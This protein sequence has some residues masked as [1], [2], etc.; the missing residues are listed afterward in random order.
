MRRLVALFY[1]I[2]A[3]ATAFSQCDGENLIQALPPAQQELLQAQADAA[4]YPEGLL[5]RATRGDTSI[6]W[7]GTYHFRH[8]MTDTHLEMIKPLIETA[9]RVYLEVSRD[10]TAQ[11]EREI[12]ADPSIMFL[13][14]GPT[15]PELLGEA[16]WATYKA[17][18]NERAIPG[19]MAAKF[20]PI[21]A[22]MM[23]GI[24]P[25]E[26]RA[27]V[28]NDSGIDELVGDYAAEIGN[29]SQSLEDFRTLLTML[30]SF[31]QDEQ[32]DMIRLF[33]A[34]ADQADD[35]AYTLRETYLAQ[36]VALI[37][38]YSKMMSL[39]LGGPDAADDFAQ[40]EELLL[41]QRNRDWVDLLLHEA[42][43]QQVFAAVGAAH[44]PGENG[45]L[46]MLE[47]E[48]FEIEAL[49]FEP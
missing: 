22:A 30:D 41:T 26:T 18:M 19:F 40:F 11:M 14:E 6:T 36:Q 21:W 20:K 45:V 24:G 7:F 12:A 32:L 37:W 15:L 44:L 43:G 39:E 13:T 35:M 31:P 16:D 17:A 4:P 27:G 2:I 46:Y 3:P 5:Y 49:P 23:L 38:E 8:R 33:F 1:F 25:C 48:G 28:L 29:P 34:Y 42:A 10:D 47:Q 9:E